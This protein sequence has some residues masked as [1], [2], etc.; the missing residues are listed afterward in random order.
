M[1]TDE[2]ELT[3]VAKYYQEGHF[4]EKKAWR[5]LRQRLPHPRKRLATVA[6]ASLIACAVVAGLLTGH[7]RTRKPSA[8]EITVTEAADSLA[9][10]GQTVST[11]VFRYE[12]TPIKDVLDELSAYYH[13]PLEASDTTRR[14]TGE[15][16]AASL[17][18]A[19]DVL[20]KTLDLKITAR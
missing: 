5:R 6:A 1:K 15:I 16:E 8:R 13:T 12:N 11:K 9:Q 7:V 19:I 2:D 18:E 4:D 17:E 20:E 3:F 14:V 10:T